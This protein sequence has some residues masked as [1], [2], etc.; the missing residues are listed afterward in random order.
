MIV[1][2][3]AESDRS[4]WD[5]YVR[6]A[7]GGLPQHLSGWRDVLART[8]GYETR[9]LFA[10][11]GEAVVG[12]LPLFL[13]RSVLV[14]HA[15]RTMPGGLC[16]DT[17]EVAAVLIAR[18]KEIARAA[19]ARSFLL[20]DTRQAWPGDLETATHHVHWVVDVRDGAE[21][22]WDRLDGNVRRQVRIARG[23]GLTVEIDRS[24]RRLGE[25]HH[26]L[27]HFTHQVGT[28][29]FGRKFLEHI[30]ATFPG[31]FNIALVS[32]GQQP[33]GAYFQFEMGNTVYGTWGATLREFLKLRPVYLAYWEMLAD[34]ATRGYH[35]LDMGRS[36]A[37]SSVSRFK[38]QWGGVARPVCQQLATLGA[39]RTAWRFARTA[40]SG[41]SRHYFN[42][43]WTRLP[44]PVV[45]FLGPRLRRHMP[46]A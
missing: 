36:P 12:V 16:A 41:A 17:P 9:Y 4:A 26:V 28:P 22:L 13:V 33:V 32:N 19:R 23:N 40:P 45:Q 10:R 27:S 21:A 1:T 44:F 20:Q 25:F 18:G 30:V 29:V 24:G 39:A 11:E 42:R 3:L 6:Q 34:T 38:G 46:F 31:G 8:Y 35:F 15:A 7:P 2:E 5:A 14:G 37:G 43:I